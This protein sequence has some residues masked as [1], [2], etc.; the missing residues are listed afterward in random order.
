[1]KYIILF[2]LIVP[3]ICSG[4][5]YY[6]SNSG[7]D[8]SSGTSEVGAWQTCYKAETSI[9]AGDTVLFMGGE[10]DEDNSGS[11]FYNHTLLVTTS[12]IDRDHPTVFAACPGYSRP[13]FYGNRG[14][15]DRRGI[16][17]KA[18]YVVLDGLEVMNARRGIEVY[19]GDYV[20]VENCVSH[21]NTDGHPGDSNG[22]G[23]ML[24]Y[25]NP[26]GDQ[27]DVCWG[28]VVRSCTLYANGTYPLGSGYD[29]NVSGIH[30]YRCD[31]CTFENNY[32]HHQNAASVISLNGQEGNGIFIKQYNDSTTI[33]GNTI[34]SC[35]LGIRIS[36]NNYNTD[37][38]HNI[39]TNCVHGIVSTHGYS[40]NSGVYI[41][42]NT[43]YATKST[44]IGAYYNQLN[45]LSN[46]NIWNNIVMNSRLWGSSYSYNLDLADY[47]NTYPNLNEDYNCYFNS[48]SSDIIRDGVD[49]GGPTVYTLTSWQSSTP[50]GD[51]DLNANPYFVDPANG[52]F[53][54]TDSSSCLTGGRGYPY[55][56]Y[57]GALGESS[58]SPVNYGKKIIQGVRK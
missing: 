45:V 53:V 15:A 40:D 8:D 4:T 44:G 20:I 51:N 5:T 47:Y 17:V 46:L 48:S 34:D 35:Y 2:L 55:E 56:I 16:Q 31:S 3:T 9:S 29:G 14:V 7:H 49:R 30:S 10:Y 12:G 27:N 26:G 43:V 52:N 39:V 11:D 54:L 33:S 13:I 57:V 24:G 18:S 38:N 25:W 41:Y 23:V 1:M 36:S 28:C 37:I 32:I 21:H 19:I 58:D 22:G 6:V 42:N 50:H